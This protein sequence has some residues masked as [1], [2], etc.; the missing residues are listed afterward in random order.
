MLLK[1]KY[2]I[3]YMSMAALFGCSSSAPQKPNIII[4]YAD[5]L[6]CGDLGC[7]GARAVKTPNIDRLASEGILFSNA[8]ACSSTCTPSRFGLLTGVYPWRYNNTGIARGDA[9]MIIKKDQYNVARMLSHSGY[10]TAAIGK[11]HLGLGEGGFNSQNWNGVITPGPKELGFGYSF[12]IPATGD[13]VPCVYLENQKIV[14]PDLNDPLEISYT[15]PFEG[16]PLGRD[17]LNKLKLQPSI[18]HDQAIVN[19]IS[20]MGY[21]RGGK[22]ALWVDEN[23]ADTITL[24]ATQF[25]ERNKNNPFFLYFATHDIH[26][27]RVPHPRFSEQTTMGARGDAIVEFDWSVGQILETLDRLHLTENTLVILSSDNGP[28]VEEGY[29]DLGHELLGNHKPTG[30]LRGGKYSAFE[31]GTRVPFIVR[32]PFQVKP[33]TSDASLSQIDLLGSMAKLCGQKIP[34]YAASDSHNSLDTWLGKSDN[35]REYV[36]EQSI[37]TL[38]ILSENW[39]L[40]TPSRA[41]KYYEEGKIELGH[42]T[43]P[44]LYNLHDDVQEKINVASKY[45]DKVQQLNTLLEEIKSKVKIE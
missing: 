22:T 2:S 15:S 27:P 44:Q 7:Y 31:G 4:I 41:Y 5:D 35:D 9:P 39:K 40:I 10:S 29:R 20:R 36:V 11:W 17:L 42:D 37:G 16:E 6:G 19:G 43:V 12:L 24:K 26:A 32:W 34:E 13:R 25:L 45:P 3:G 28:V 21:S 8:Y 30:E 23:M 14:N 18:G 33:G 1:F 38:S